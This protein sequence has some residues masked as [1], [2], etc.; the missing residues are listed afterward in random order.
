MVRPGRTREAADDVVQE[1][2]IRARAYAPEGLTRHPKALLLKIAR[3]IIL[4]AARDAS[5]KK[6][7]PMGYEP[8]TWQPADQY[9]RILLAEIIAA[10]PQPYRDTF[11]LSR[12]DGMTYAEIA[13]AQGVTVKVV[14]W[15]VARAL[16]ICTERMR[17]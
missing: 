12:F 7:D 16:A 3:S 8:A 11:I 17:D 4:N 5:R 9:Q 2:F 15:R 14:E 13:R 10:I 6:R 1:T